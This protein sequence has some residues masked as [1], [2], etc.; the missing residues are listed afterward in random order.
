MDCKGFLQEA[1]DFAIDRVN[2]LIDILNKVN[3]TTDIG[4]VGDVT[5]PNAPDLSRMRVFGGGAQGRNRRDGS[6]GSSTAPQ[7]LIIQVN[8][9]EFA[10][11]TMEVLDGQIR[12]RQPGVMIT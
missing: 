2:D 1:I 8:G 12:V 6:G 9:R 11:A 7:P 3:P 4:R 5:V 10:R